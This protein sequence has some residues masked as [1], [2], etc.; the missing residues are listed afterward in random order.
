MDRFTQAAV[1]FTAVVC[2]ICACISG[3]CQTVRARNDKSVIEHQRQI[4]RLEE[5]LRNRDRTVDNALRELNSISARST[6]MEGTVDEVIELFGE[7]Q[8]RVDQLIRDYYTIRASTQ[9]D[10]K[11][12]TQT[13]SSL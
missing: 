1:S 3:G 11:Y 2:V 6:A 9:E 12:S 8:R 13:D 7:Y 10:K 4:D 5:E